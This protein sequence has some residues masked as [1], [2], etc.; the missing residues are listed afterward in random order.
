MSD[1]R[2]SQDQPGLWDQPTTAQSSNQRDPRRRASQAVKPRAA[3][4]EDDQQAT[5]AAPSTA[6]AARQGFD[7]EDLWDADRVAVYLGVPKQTLYA[8]RHSGKGPKGFRVGKHLR[9]RARTVVEWT[10][11]LERDQ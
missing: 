10:L 4:Q 3:G 2:S 8:W 11:E 9:W 6:P 1:N 5:T 7:V